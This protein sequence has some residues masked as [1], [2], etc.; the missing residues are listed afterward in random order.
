[1]SISKKHAHKAF[2]TS[3][4]RIFL[5]EIAA[6]FHCVSGRISVCRGV[7]IIYML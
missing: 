3:L 6:L 4:L 1:M 7:H 2:L 5:N